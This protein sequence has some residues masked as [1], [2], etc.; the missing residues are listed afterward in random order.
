VIDVMR[1]LESLT[2]CVFGG[3]LKTA[4]GLS[5]TLSPSWLGTDPAFAFGMTVVRRICS[6]VLTPKTLINSL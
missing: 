5:P 6:K 1:K 3:I 2:G 4:G